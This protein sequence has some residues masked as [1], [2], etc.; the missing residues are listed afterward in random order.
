MNRLVKVNKRPQSLNTDTNPEGLQNSAIHS[1][2]FFLKSFFRRHMQPS[3]ARHKLY[4]PVPALKKKG[5]D[6]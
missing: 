5:H 3:G 2:I 4:L 6:F 1:P